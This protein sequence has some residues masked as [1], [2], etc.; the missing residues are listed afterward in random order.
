MEPCDV[1]AEIA[2]LT[3]A[4]ATMRKTWMPLYEKYSDGILS[5]EAFL[6]E[7]QK[8]DEDVKKLETQLSEL[9]YTQSEQ[10]AK[11]DTMRDDISQLEQYVNQMELTEEIKEKFID[12][13]MVY[14]NNRIEIYWKYDIDFSSRKAVYKCG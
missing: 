12:K 7:T 6:I 13:V 4:I 5:R 2:A 3:N 11:I 14:G 1:N 9:M 10:N 8:Y